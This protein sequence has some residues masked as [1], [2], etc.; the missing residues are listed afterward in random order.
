LLVRSELSLAALHDAGARFDPA[1]AFTLAARM[2]DPAWTVGARFTI[3]HRT[4]DTSTADAHLVV[5]DGAP[6]SAGEGEP[7]GPADAAI[8][9]PV[10]AFPAAMTDALREAGAAPRPLAQLAAWL[11][12][13]QSG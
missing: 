10:D 12:R 1:L 2:I 6:V 9:A 8:V 5:K 3:A 11:E 4:A 7:A 13:A